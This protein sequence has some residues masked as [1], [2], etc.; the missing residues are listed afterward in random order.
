MAI[1][2]RYCAFGDFRAADCVKLCCVANRLGVGQEEEGVDQF[3]VE[4]A[5]YIDDEENYLT[6]DLRAAAKLVSH[7]R[8]IA[9][10]GW[11]FI[12]PIHFRNALELYIAE[13]I[14]GVKLHTQCGS[15]SVITALRK[16]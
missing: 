11:T 2:S 12:F 8:T 16:N 10:R 13:R 3:I 6:F 7:K 14:N 15:F 4:I 9:P 5:G 1:R